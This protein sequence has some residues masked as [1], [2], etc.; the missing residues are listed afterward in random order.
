M[1]NPRCVGLFYVYLVRHFVDF[2][3]SLPNRRSISNLVYLEPLP[4][5][6]LS[7]PIPGTYGFDL[8]WYMGST[9]TSICKLFVI[10]ESALS[11]SGTK[12]LG[13]VPF[14]IVEQ[15]YG[16]LLQWAADLPNS[17]ARRD[18]TPH[19]VMNIQ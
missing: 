6:P 11:Y 10:A 3:E 12:T 8:P 15:T 14:H 16:Q 2:H 9:F 1:G 13:Q 19:H 5:P 4:K 7:L 17:C 18:I